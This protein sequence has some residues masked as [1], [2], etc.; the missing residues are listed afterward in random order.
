MWKAFDK[1]THKYFA[2]KIHLKGDGEKAAQE[3]VKEYTRVMHI[4]HDNLLTP[5]HVD[6]T[7][8][9]VP[10]LVM[11]LC[12]SDLSEKDLSEIEVWHLIRDVSAGLKRLA[13]NK[14]A[15]E[16]LDGSSSEV[17]DPIIH[18][19]IKPAN[20]L[21]RAN[22]MYA[23]SDF[24]ISK[25]R[26]SS[27]SSTM[28]AEHDVDSAMTI[29]YA[30]PERF[31]RGKGISVLA[32]DIWSLGAMLFEIV[33]GRRPFAECGG[34]CLN[35]TIGLKIPEIMRKGFS[36]ELKQLI[37]DCMAKEPAHRP[38]ADQLYIYAEE[39]LKGEPRKVEWPGAPKEIKT[40]KT[41][42]QKS[43]KG[44]VS[45]DETSTTS[46]TPD[47][48]PIPH[49][50]P[51][52]LENLSKFWHKYNTILIFALILF[53]IG[54]L[55]ILIMLQNGSDNSH[56][57]DSRIDSSNI[58]NLRIDSSNIVVDTPASIPEEFVLC[59][60]GTLYHY[61][62]HG[63]YVDVNLDSFYISKYELTQK[64]WK[65]F[66]SEDTFYHIYY[67]L[68]P[69]T[70]FI[71]S[72]LQGDSLPVDVNFTLAC[73]Y[74]NRRSNEEGYSGFYYI[75][76]HKLTF[77]PQG[78]GYR[79][80]NRY[81]WAYAARGGERK[82]TKYAAG[83]NINEIAWYG[84]NSGGRPHNVGQK[85]PN[86]I[87][88]YDMNGNVSES[89]WPSEKHRSTACALECHPSYFGAWIGF[90]EN[91]IWN[92]SAGV[93]LVLV[94]KGMK[95]NNIQYYQMEHYPIN[96]TLQTLLPTIQ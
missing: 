33:E 54:I 1:V 80:P 9:T 77:N 31:P 24:G 93:R 26:L 8:G 41:K 94:P 67:R 53:I 71:K 30:A 17:A 84:G 21:I 78:N 10:Y 11:E 62:H 60:K 23:I 72:N 59:P 25:R 36:D 43:F 92:S 87:G 2:I 38:H 46:P 66:I 58:D 19:D 68:D 44:A 12:N 28:D 22:G 56:K 47:P 14:R 4:H 64:E 74:C 48:D 35:P 45:V 75:K 27:L 96:D 63:E 3:I 89:L 73:V 69:Y 95:N 42:R 85:K 65:R 34:D 81:E 52:S 18:Q 20:I 70:G 39:V 82:H 88:L 83:D 91:E 90:A 76:D 15:K 5:S 7:E 86:S 51:F 79:L 6:I 37:Y 57:D 16:R 50:V 61:S 29:D 40:D 13:E 32:S 55:L 49:S